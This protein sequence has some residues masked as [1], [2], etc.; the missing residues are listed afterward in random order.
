MKRFLS[1][2]AFC[3][4]ILS[5]NT[6]GRLKKDLPES[7]VFYFISHKGS[8]QLVVQEVTKNT[9]LSIG[10]YTSYDVIIGMPLH[11]NLPERVTALVARDTPTYVVGDTIS[12]YP[13]NLSSSTR[14][15]Y[16]VNDTVIDKRPVTQ[17]IGAKHPAIWG[18]V[19]R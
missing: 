5:C 18:K 6:S 13:L 2:C 1:A 17:F 16:L 4:I 7:S 10:G 3:V 8:F 15:C 14:L 19:V 12:I 11:T 9:G